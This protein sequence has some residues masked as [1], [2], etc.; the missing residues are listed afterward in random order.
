MDAFEK[1]MSQPHL[2][3][4]KQQHYVPR[5]YLAGFA[6]KNQ[7][8]VFDRRTGAVKLRTPEHT[9]RIPNLYTFD[10]KQDRR[11]YDIEKMFGYYE[12]KVAPI[13][14][15]VAARER[16]GEEDREHLTAY[17]ALA[18]LRTPA[19]I[20]EAKAVHAGFTKARSLLMFSTEKGAL[21]ILKEMEGPDAREE[22]LRGD[23][24]RIARMV[25]DDA[26]TVEVDGGFALGK[27]LQKFKVIAEAM[28]P[29]DWMVLYTRS[30][31]E[32]FLTTD[33][34]VVL[35]I[36]SSA[37]RHLPH[38]YGSA[39]AQ[40]LCPLTHNCAVVMSGD[41]GRNGRM[42]ITAE[43]LDRFNLTVAADSHRYVFGRDADLVKSVT[44]ELQLASRKWTPKYRVGIGQRVPGSGVWDVFVKRTGE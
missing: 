22:E 40:I 29:R 6:R 33:M 10:D 2:D 34:P 25:R 28:H 18:A 13:I 20:I 9:A 43:A 31:A 27:S 32:S 12:D 17:L 44:D 16:I 24:E 15:R 30:D 7:L 42:E 21:R 38:G 8:A 37:M 14:T 23:A 3:G 35:T 26:Y 4:A 5:F 1:L 41:Q 36:T 39:H 19:A 11:R